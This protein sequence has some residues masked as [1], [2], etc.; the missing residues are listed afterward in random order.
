MNVS[1]R[2]EDKRINLLADARNSRQKSPAAIAMETLSVISTFVED[3]KASLKKMFLSVCIFF[4]LHS[5][6]LVRVT[7]VVA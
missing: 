2:C 6:W 4:F 3:H 7:L 5:W 1:R